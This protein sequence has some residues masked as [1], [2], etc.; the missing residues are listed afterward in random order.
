MLGI[1]IWRSQLVPEVVPPPVSGE[2][3]AD[4]FTDTAGVTL[5]AHTPSG[6]GTWTKHAD[7]TCD[8]VIT[9]ANRVRQGGTAGQIGL[10]YHS[11]TPS[12]ADYTVSGVVRLVTDNGVS[13]VA[14]AARL[15]VTTGACYWF[16]LS[17]FS[18]GWR[19]FYYNGSGGFTQIGTTVAQGTASG[20]EFAA[21]LNVNGSTLTCS[22]DG[23]PIIT[24]SDANLSAAG[25]AGIFVDAVASNTTGVHLDTFVATT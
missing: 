14:L 16:G 19:L 6:G 24:Q 13:N 10:Y 23:V 9:D 22:V 17:V 12:A 2:F 18:N 4:N 7:S 8:I 3:A 20:Q 21:A 1:S 15:D 5:Q 11:G 25:R